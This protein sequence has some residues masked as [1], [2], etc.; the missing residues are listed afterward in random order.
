MLLLLD[1]A[2]PGLHPPVVDGALALLP[3]LLVVARVD[4]PKMAGLWGQDTGIRDKHVVGV[5]S[6]PNTI[7]AQA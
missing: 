7:Y 2:E 3:L 4:Q 6:S 5:S 1:V